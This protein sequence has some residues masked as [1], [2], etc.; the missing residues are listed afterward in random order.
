MGKKNTPITLIILIIFSLLLAACQLGAETGEEAPSEVD[1]SED[2][3]ESM[4][5]D[6]AMGDAAD[7]AGLVYETLVKIEGGQPVPGLLILRRRAHSDGLRNHGTRPPHPPDGFLDA[8]R[9]A[10]VRGSS[11]SKVTRIPI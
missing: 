7:A 9:L 10:H 6:P 2:P 1:S 8:E 3:G 4:T 11:W 5:F